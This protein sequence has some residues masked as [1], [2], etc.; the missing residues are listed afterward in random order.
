MHCAAMGSTHGSVVSG[1][2]HLLCLCPGLWL[3]EAHSQITKASP[4]LSR[5]FS[6]VNF[7]LWESFEIF[8]FSRVLPFCVPGLFIFYI[9]TYM[10][11]LHRCN[12]DTHCITKMHVAGRGLFTMKQAGPGTVHIF[13]F[14]LRRQRQ[15]FLCGFPLSPP[16]DYKGSSRPARSLQ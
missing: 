5:S 14:A 3:P 1:R 11:S 9:C 8:F 10:G 12:K 13:N 15:T 4:L 6:N 7:Y 2:A 16:Q